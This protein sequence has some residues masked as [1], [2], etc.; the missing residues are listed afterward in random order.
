MGSKTHTLTHSLTPL[1]WSLSHAHTHTHSRALPAHATRALHPTGQPLLMPGAGG[2][3]RREADERGSGGRERR[4]GGEERGHTPWR[5]TGPAPPAPTTVAVTV[6]A[7]SLLG[8][9]H[10]LQASR[11]WKLQ[12][13]RRRGTREEGQRGRGEGR[14]ESAR[15]ASAACPAAGHGHGR[16]PAAGAP[17]RR[18]PALSARAHLMLVQALQRQS[19]GRV[20]WPGCRPGSAATA[21][22]ASAPSAGLPT[23]HLWQASRNW[24]LREQR[25]KE[26][27]R[28]GSAGGRR[29]AAESC[30]QPRRCWP[31]ASAGR[32]PSSCAH[33]MLPQ[34]VQRQ[35]PGLMVCPG[36]RP[37]VWPP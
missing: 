11:N 17:R 29:R 23:P 19:P 37:A 8:A 6:S 31:N 10:L 26:E 4:A 34:L 13:E 36:C 24:K 5:P 16:L 30:R 20:I 22:V 35:S 32:S 9:P 2:G 28:A 14:P 7:S 1:A 15:L 18:Q 21:M 12:E 25:T 33:L 3:P 27:E